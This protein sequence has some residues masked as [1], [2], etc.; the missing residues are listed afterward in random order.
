MVAA[1]FVLAEYNHTADRKKLEERRMTSTQAANKA[2]LSPVI[3]GKRQF[4]KYVM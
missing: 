4:W 3:A 2:L 1:R